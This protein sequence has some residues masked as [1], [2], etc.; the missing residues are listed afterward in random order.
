MIFGKYANLYDLYYAEKNYAAEVDFVLGMAARFS[1]G[2]PASVLDMGCGT[3]RHLLE[4]SRRGLA[5]AGFDMSE[6]MLAQARKRLAGRDVTLAQGNLTDFA[7]GL[8]YDLVVSMFAVMGYLTTNGDLVAGL[9]T[10]RRHLRP[11]GLFVFDGWFG[12]AV[13]ANKPEI[14]THEY[15]D[16]SQTVRRRAVPV[17]DPVRQT[18][19]VRYEVRTYEGAKLLQEVQEE[20][21]M[22]F[23]FVREVAL[24]MDAAGLELAHACPFLQADGTLALDTWNVS[25]VARKKK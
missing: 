18:V 25:F 14:R 3:G 5:C 19:Q 9:R 1:G 21:C 2:S 4:F 11:G 16:G 13:L 15:A 17:L 23:M 12:P 24:A 20:H 10:A 22:R 8:T 7:N 6:A